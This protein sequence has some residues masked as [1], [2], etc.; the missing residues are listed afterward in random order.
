VHRVLRRQLE[1][2]KPI[3]QTHF[4]IVISLHRLLVKVETLS[5]TFLHE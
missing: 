3:P 4:T 5:A 1:H 2:L